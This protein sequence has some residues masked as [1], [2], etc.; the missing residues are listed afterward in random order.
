[1]VLVNI[2]EGTDPRPEIERYLELWGFQG[3]ILLDETGD[4][5]REVGVR[6]IPTNVVVDRD[7]VVRI[8]GA[9]RFGELEAALDTLR[10]S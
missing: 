3:T 9:T 2:W 5:A 6:G 1:V 7:G 4:F 8:V 10:D